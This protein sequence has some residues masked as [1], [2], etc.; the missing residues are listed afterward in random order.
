MRQN[1]CRYCALA[2]EYKNIHRMSY[3]QECYRCENRKKHEEYLKSK[4]KFE[5]GEQIQSL[6]EL[7][8]QE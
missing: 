2:Y 7:L 6:N 4:R 8:Q 5:I 1:P 3:S